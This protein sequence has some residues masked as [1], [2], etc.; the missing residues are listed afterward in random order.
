M[1][2]LDK[3]NQTMTDDLKQTAVLPP[4]AAADDDSISTTIPCTLAQANQ[5]NQKSR[6]SRKSTREKIE[7][8]VS[9]GTKNYPAY[10]KLIYTGESDISS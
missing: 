9:E 1:K 5:I 3:N 2:E 4:S 7:K 6:T 10:L 8:L